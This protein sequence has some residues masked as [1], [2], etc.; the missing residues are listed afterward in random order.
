[1]AYANCFNN[2]NNQAALISFNSTYIEFYR[3]NDSW[4]SFKNNSSGMYIYGAGV[5]M[6]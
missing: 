2:N 5:Y 1:M 6:A 4:N 3:D